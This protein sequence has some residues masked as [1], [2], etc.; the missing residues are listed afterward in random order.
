MRA[1]TPASLRVVAAMACGLWAV[2]CSVATL[3]P[4]GELSPFGHARHS[5]VPTA[6]AIDSAVPAPPASTAEIESGAEDG[7]FQTSHPR[8]QGFLDAYRTRLRDFLTLALQRASKYLPK[9]ESI[10]AEEGV[11]PELVYVTLVESGFRLHA[12]SPA[13]AVGPWQF[14]RGTGRRYG[15]RIDGYVDERRDP[16]KATRAA[17]RYF[18]DLYDTFGDWHLSLAAYNR[19]EGNIAR[20]RDWQKIDNYWEMSARGYLPRETMSFVPRV[21]A[22]MEI[23][24]APEEY[25]F[26]VVPDPPAGYD[27][28]NIDSPISLQTVAEPSGSDVATISEL[29]PALRRGVVPPEGYVVRLPKGTRSRFE[30]SYAQWKRQPKPPPLASH[31]ARSSARTHRVR[32]GESPGSIARRYGVSVT[33]LMRANGIRDP[34]ALAIGRVLQ[35]PAVRS[36][37]ARPGPVAARRK[38]PTRRTLN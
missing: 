29:N 22:A 6:P 33:A 3:R 26:D 9:M 34:R 8:V 36:E 27:L 18:R 5:H 15:L 2:G 21:L 19:G 1:A 35:I 12:A 31:V 24:R 25:G 28:M 17:A 32:R 4:A 30:I 14:V 13:G 38:A 7:P 37:P 10:L 11:P 20:I 23:G 16:V